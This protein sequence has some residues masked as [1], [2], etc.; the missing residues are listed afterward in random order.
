MSLWTEE[1][2]R[3][4]GIATQLK[5]EMENWAKKNHIKRIDTTI[6]MKNTKMLSINEKMGYEIK[7]LRMEKI[8]TQ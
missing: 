3:G 6:N 2:F 4:Q 8:I 5:Q 7:Y 1:K